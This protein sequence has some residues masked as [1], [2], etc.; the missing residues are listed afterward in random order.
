MMDMVEFANQLLRQMGTAQS[1]VPQDEYPEDPDH[2]DSDAAN[3]GAREQQ[4]QQEHS[5]G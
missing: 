4:D 3:L 2:D 5:N 1:T